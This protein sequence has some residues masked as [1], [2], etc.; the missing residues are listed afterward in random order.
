LSKPY[1]GPS[2]PEGQ[3]AVQPDK[4]NDYGKELIHFLLILSSLKES[5]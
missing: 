5:N 2:L 1:T 3:P 4:E